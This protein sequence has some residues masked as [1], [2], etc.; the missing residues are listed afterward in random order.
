MA[1]LTM[2][3]LPLCGAFVHVAVAAWL[4]GYD[5]HQL[6]RM[7][8][9][10]I[11]LRGVVSY[12][13][14]GLRTAPDEATAQLCA[15]VAVIQFLVVAVS[16]HFIWLWTERQM[17][18]LGLVALYGA[19]AVGMGLMVAADWHGVR[20]IGELWALDFNGIALPGKLLFLFAASVVW[21]G[22]LIGI[23]WVITQPRG[24]RGRHLWIL[25][26]MVLPPVGVIFLEVLPRIVGAT[27]GQLVG[28]AVVIP[29]T[30]IL[31]YG[32]SRHEAITPL[33]NSRQVIRCLNEALA[34]TDPRGIIR[35]A[36]P[37]LCRLTGYPAGELEGRDLGVLWDHAAS[38]P[39]GFDMR[40]RRGHDTLT[41]G[42]L[43][44]QTGMSVPV[45]LSIAPVR[46]DQE[47]V[48]GLV[49]T[50]RDITV[51]KRTEGELR[52][53]KDAAKAATRAKSDFLA[54]MSHEIRTPMNGVIGMTEVLRDTRLSP[55]QRDY[56]DTI[57][58]SGQT[59]LD[60]INDI[61][62]FSKIEAGR[63]EIEDAAF[64]VRALIQ[65]VVDLCQGNADRKGLSL[66]AWVDPGVPK[67]AFADPIRLRQ[68]LVNL[69]TNA[70]KFTG[71]GF[72]EIRAR[73]EP[74]GRDG[75]WLDF[76]VE[77]TGI[78][79]PQDRMDRLFESFSQVDS[80]VTRRFGGTGLG[81]AISKRLAERM[82][83]GISARSVEGRGSTFHVRV[84]AGSARVT[85]P[86]TIDLGTVLYQDSRR[87]R[88]LLAEDNPVNQKVAM[89]FLER[90]GYECEVVQDGEQAL[91][92][93]ANGNFDVV[94][95]DV[96]MPVMDGLEATRRLRTWNRDIYVIAMT[97]NALRGDREACL[98]AGMDDYLS[99]PV[100]PERLAEALQMARVALEDTLQ[101]VRPTPRQPL[102]LLE[103]KKP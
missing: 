64:D 49:A 4:W 66:R 19:A 45:L 8:A 44:T 40:W 81:L 54:T 67:R 22:A 88:V 90:L 86:E 24:N 13:S 18:R 33:T 101:G 51:R 71:D 84:R 73:A 95:M 62:D 55:D 30:L 103:R 9:I 26:G 2:L 59:L 83:G 23:H 74:R 15:D 72:V 5:R 56:V 69:V 34:I 42:A 41:E 79:I 91:E 89:L 20:R 27:E 96:Q 102:T 68:I 3:W 46:D 63:I 60:I 75:W 48:L 37:A 35:L 65:E 1:N 87:R 14:Y 98:E 52:K 80:S 70:V 25:A 76:A 97:A 11:L 31:A 94:L 28:P 43:M 47:R 32:M 58:L 99:K 50:M 21:I 36:N 38:W 92:A 6:N 100:T 93:I 7:A 53:A 77:D 10:V 29:A 16:F 85:E 57:K 61:L 39:S 78:G 17:S 12:L 82:G